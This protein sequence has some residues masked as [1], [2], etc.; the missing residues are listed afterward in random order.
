MVYGA[1]VAKVCSRSHGQPPLGLRSC[2][3][4]F[5]SC[6]RASEDSPM[7][8]TFRAHPIEGVDHSGRRS[9]D[10]V[11]AERDVDDV[12]LIIARADAAAALP[13]VLRIEEKTHRHFERAFDFARIEHQLESRL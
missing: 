1:I 5:S 8:R 3:I 13:M 7:V 2:S 4:T 11:L 9:P 10:V 12:D 6:F